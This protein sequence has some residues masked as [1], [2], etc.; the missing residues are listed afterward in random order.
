MLSIL[1]D[2][3]NSLKMASTSLG[4]IVH[5]NN[6]TMVV[7]LCAG[8][9]VVHEKWFRDDGQLQAVT[10]YKHPGV[11]LSKKLCTNTILFES[12]KVASLQIKSCGKD[13][14]LYNYFNFSMPR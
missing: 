5:T 10:Q 4:V 6:T 11:M 8:Y 12:A 1:Q 14:H 7:S 3:I 2:E 9:L 13:F